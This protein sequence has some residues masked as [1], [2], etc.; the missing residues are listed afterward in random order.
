[1]SHD[2]IVVPRSLRM[3]QREAAPISLP[4]RAALGNVLNIAAGKGPS[5]DVTLTSNVM[6]RTDPKMDR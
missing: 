3:F 2:L 1:M 4:A 5:G 6:L